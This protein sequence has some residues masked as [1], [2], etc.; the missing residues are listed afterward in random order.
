MNTAGDSRREFTVDRNCARTKVK[1][2]YRLRS[3]V[4]HCLRNKWNKTHGNARD[5]VYEAAE[6]L[7]GLVHCD[8]FDRLLGGAIGL[9]ST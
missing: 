6:D 9:A 3:E 8:D 2:S 5:F 4:Y 7:R 1:V